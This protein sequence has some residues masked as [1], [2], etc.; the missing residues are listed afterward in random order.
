MK[1][2]E[3]A[4]KALDATLENRKMFL[5]L[6]LQLFA[7]GDP[8][9]PPTDP[10]DPPADPQDPP[11]DPQDPPANPGKTFT[12]EDVNGIAAKEAKKAQ[13]KLLKQLGVKDIKSVKDGLE[14][15]KEITDAQKT[16]ADK[17]LE[18]LTT[19][20]TD[21]QTLSA[22]VG[23]LTAQL[24]ALKAGV[25]SDSLEDVIVLANNLV[26]DDTTIDD[27]IVQVLKKYP[28]FKAAG[29]TKQEDKKP[30]P[31]FTDGE[32]KNKQKQSDNDAWVQAFNFGGTIK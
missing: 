31:K 24:A 7:E 5:P 14:K 17:A 26:N 30:K 1:Q 2:L 15:L 12:Q 8:Q 9:D 11:A 28:H 18:K 27:A 10:Q 20:E 21:N 32:H 29:E 13:E 6:D 19:L 23:T 22:T 3:N 25:N 4:K 16:D